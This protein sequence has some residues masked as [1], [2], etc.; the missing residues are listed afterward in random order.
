MNIISQPASTETDSART[1]IAKNKIE[2][3]LY[4]APTLF[5]LHYIPAQLGS[6]SC[7]SIFY[8]WTLKSEWRASWRCV[9]DFPFRLLNR[10]LFGVVRQKRKKRRK[11]F[12]I[13]IF[14]RKWTRHEPERSEEKR[15][16][17]KSP[18]AKC[19][20]LATAHNFAVIYHVSDCCIM[21]RSY[22]KRK[23]R[24]NIKRTCKRHKKRLWI[25]RKLLGISFNSGKMENEGKTENLFLFSSDFSI[26]KISENYFS[27]SFV[28]HFHGNYFNKCFWFCMCA[29]GDEK[30]FRSSY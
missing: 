2:E 16:E 12:H 5:T 18:D 13:K 9:F 28:R 1:N 26:R 7:D 23:E 24:K 21:F 19:G 4:Y 11:S 22:C 20:S 15:M 3:N 14:M 17:W 27:S 29:M 8:A 30:L 25:E 10:G 6:F